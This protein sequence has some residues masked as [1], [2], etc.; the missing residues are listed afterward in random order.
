MFITFFPFP[1]CFFKICLWD[2]V[3]VVDRNNFDLNK[4]SLK[5]IEPS[6][7]IR[8]HS[9]TPYSFSE[10]PAVMAMVR[11]AGSASM[12]HPLRWQPAP[13]IINCCRDFFEV[14]DIA[15][16]QKKNPNLSELFNVMRVCQ[17]HWDW[18][19]PSTRKRCSWED[20]PR[21][22]EGVMSAWCSSGL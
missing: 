7:T 10:K 4:S 22:G 12:F 5:A 16:C 2:V 3:D 15:L 8:H 17:S 6:K 14:T 9:A 21:I 11:F 19:R 18:N 13:S 20:C 1:L